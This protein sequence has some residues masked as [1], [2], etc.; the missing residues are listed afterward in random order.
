MKKET[1]TWVW[2]GIIVVAVALM[3]WGARAQQTNAGTWEDTDV[4]CLG[5]GHQNAMQH[6]HANLSV[7][8]DGEPQS[9]PSGVGINADC[10][11][12]THTHDASGEIHVETADTNAVLTL[13]D[14][15]TVWDQP[16]SDSEEYE[17]TITVNGEEFEE[18]TY[19]FADGDVVEVSYRSV[20]GTS[21]ATTSQQAGMTSTSS[22]Q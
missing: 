17:K 3:M 21:T 8:V 14:F 4:A 5:G 12:E 16:F 10:M 1:S 19:G 20:T 13:E 7:T 18:E 11:A 9:I 15:M 22:A 6:I 2:V